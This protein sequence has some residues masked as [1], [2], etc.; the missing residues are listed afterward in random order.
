MGIKTNIK[1]PQP[2]EYPGL[3][4]LWAAAVRSTHDFLREP[5]FQAIKEL[6]GS[7]YL[8]AMRLYGFYYSA[9]ETAGRRDLSFGAA[10]LSRQDAFPENGLCAGFIGHSDVS[11]TALRRLP[12][13][14]FAQI[15]AVQVEMLFVDPAF[16]RR[17]IGR[18]LLDYS[19]AMYPSLFLDVNEQNRAGVCFYQKYGFQI[20][21]R[22]AK[23]G[24]GRPYPLLHLWRRPRS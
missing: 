11:E 2:E 24:Q 8:P 19:G 7:T 23:D 4:D 3:V 10:V 21:A 18:A 14:G 13:A 5:D 16:Q 20:L 1:I 15:P 17:G 22:S 9:S 6:V 12:D